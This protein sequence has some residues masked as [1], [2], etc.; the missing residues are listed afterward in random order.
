MSDPFLTLNF[1]QNRPTGALSQ[2]GTGV[3]GIVQMY[4]Q[5]QQQ[6]AMNQAYQDSLALYM[7]NQTPENLMALYQAAEP[8]G[9]FESIRSSVADMTAEQRQAEVSQ[10]MDVLAPLST[11]N[12]DVALSNLDKQIQAYTNAGDT[13]EVAALTQLRQ[14]ISDGKISEAQALLSMGMGVTEEGRAALESMNAYS[15]ERRAQETQ[16]LDVL[17]T[18]RDLEIYSQEELDSLIAATEDDPQFG[19]MIR[20]TL[21]YAAIA[22]NAGLDPDTVLDFDQQWNK[23]FFD[24]T[25]SLRNA[26]ISNSSVQDAFRQ[27]VA[28]DGGANGLYDLTMMNLFQRQI[29]EATVRESDLQNIQSSLSA[30]GGLQRMIEQVTTGSKL[31]AQQRQIVSEL[32]DQLLQNQESYVN[33]YVYPSIKAS[34][35]AL[36][37][38]E[39]GDD[40]YQR[41]FGEYRPLGGGTSVQ[42]GNL[43]QVRSLVSS[44][45]DKNGDGLDDDDGFDIRNASESE[46]RRHYANTLQQIN[47]GTFNAGGV[48]ASAPENTS[49]YEDL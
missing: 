3:G 48:G 16:A 4:R 33:D 38:T 40:R 37:Q 42:S 29:D 7:Q 27:A 2:L 18:A 17:E 47:Q 24:R 22:K 30:F 12:T 10:T 46:L 28:N 31:N 15:Q 1:A 21:N 39:V 20:R 13:Q 8:L 5:Q 32:S 44:A 45:W 9:K 25:E 11:G 6:K 34:V 49:N 23:A 36:G 41:V 26:T 19:N 35:D 43:E 14:A